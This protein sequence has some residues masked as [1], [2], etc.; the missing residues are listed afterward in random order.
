V[1]LVVEFLNANGAAVTSSEVTIPVLMPGLPS[2]V[3]VAVSGQGIVSW[4]YR[5]K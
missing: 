5:V 1:T 3:S 4:K 2:Q